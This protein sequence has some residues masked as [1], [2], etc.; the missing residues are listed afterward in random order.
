[1]VIAFTYDT[2][3]KALVHGFS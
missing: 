3:N 2:T 1:V